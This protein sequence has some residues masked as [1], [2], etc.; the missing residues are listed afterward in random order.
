M[1]LDKI[2]IS[3]MLRLSF[4][5]DK[6][7]IITIKKTI[8]QYTALDLN[9]LF[10]EHEYSEIWTFVTFKNWILVTFNNCVNYLTQSIFWKPKNIEQTIVQ[11]NRKRYSIPSTQFNPFFMNKF[12][13]I[14][15]I[16][17]RERKTIIITF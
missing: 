17:F 16:R 3:N 8:Q 13:F 10:S 7:K 5:P 1:K 14:E 6:R 12:V 11:E 15:S 4:P 2:Q 9:V